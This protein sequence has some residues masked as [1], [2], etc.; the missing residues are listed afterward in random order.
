MRAFYVRP[1]CDGGYGAGDGT[2]YENAWNGFA[3]V[4]WEVL[5]AFAPAAVVVCGAPAGRER[6][7]A[8]EV[9]WAQ[10]APLKK[11]A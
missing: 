10:R 9:H 1:E 4:D 11:A 5:A 2:S 3:C 8:L 6:R 7:I